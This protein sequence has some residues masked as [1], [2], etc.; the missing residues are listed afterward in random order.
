[1]VFWF[2]ATYC[3]SQLLQAPGRIVE[4]GAPTGIGQLTHLTLRDR[5]LR[6]GQLGLAVVILKPEVLS[7]SSSRSAG[8][9]EMPQ[10]ARNLLLALDE[11]S[12]RMRF[13]LR[14]RDTRSTR[15]FDDV[16][17]SEG[18]EV[19][20]TPVRA[21][22]AN[23]HAERWVR[24]VRAECLGW[25]A[26]RRPR[27]PRAGPPGLR[28]ALQRP[29]AAPGP[30]AA[31]AGS[32]SPTGP[33]RQRAAGPSPPTRPA[34]RPPPRVPASCMNAFAHPTGLLHEHRRAAWPHLCTLWAR[35]TRAV[36]SVID[37]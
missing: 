33:H 23:A 37:R 29:S 3:S 1:M 8:M 34:R 18:A 26:D 2:S 13:L 11:Q 15:A 35:V 12:L 32:S 7:I 27:P 25:A 17:R 22:N 19:L 16:M 5:A 20:L 36:R 24:T 10:Q 28:S 21:P 9:P 30:L 14:D 6:D 31:A 4:R